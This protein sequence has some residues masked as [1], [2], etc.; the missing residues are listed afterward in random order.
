MKRSTAINLILLPLFVLFF[1]LA[2][3]MQHR[4]LEGTRKAAP[5]AE[6][7]LAGRSGEMLRLLALRYDMLAADFLWLRSIQSFGGRGMTNRDWK[8]IYN[9]FDAITEL[10]PYFEQAYTFGNMVIGDEGGQ[11]LQGLELLNKGMFH[12]TRQYRIPF[13]GMYVT[14]WQMGDTRRA[15]WYGHIASRRQDSPD[16][17]PRMVAYIEVKSGA[18]YIGFDRFV[19]NLLQGIESKDYSLQNIGMTKTAETIDKWNK[20]LIGQAIDQYTSSTGKLPRRLDEVANQPALQNYEVAS[21]TKL[22]ATVE[23]CSRA[24]GL[25]GINEDLL[26]GVALPTPPEMAQAVQEMPPT[27]GVK[28]LTELQNK[29]FRQAIV[30]RSGIPPHPAGYHYVL[31]QANLGNPLFTPKDALTEDHELEALLQEILLSVRSEIA[32]RTNELGHKPKDLHE[33]FYTDFNTTEPFGGKWTYDPN[34]GDFH[35][36]SR[37]NL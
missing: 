17:V 22:L 11:Q 20:D 8:P 23:A 7:S 21:M 5:F 19:T 9:L 28:K 31:N 29:I 4:Q 12:L 30:K 27:K 13:E 10:D 3:F 37:P 24:L 2:V 32:K 6:W 1:G 26:K 14:H 25:N 34:T 36:S 18:Y 33:V 15:R 16:W 35:S